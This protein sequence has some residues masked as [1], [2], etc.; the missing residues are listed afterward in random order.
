MKQVIREVLGFGDQS[1]QVPMFVYESVEEADKDAGRQGAGLEEMNNNLIYR[2]CQADARELIV[3]VVQQLTK[4][5]FLMVD[6]GEKDEKGQ[7][8][9]ERDMDRDSDAKYVKRA[10]TA[11]PAVTFESVQKLVTQRANGYT[12]KDEEGKDVKVEAIRTDIRRKTRAP[13]KP[14]VL[15]QRYKNTATGILKANNVAKFNKALAKFGLAQFAPT[16]KLEADVVALGWLCKAYQDAVAEEST[17]QFV[18]Q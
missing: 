16:G 4:V 18:A 9:M 14:K 6:S 1:F 17:G 12:Y 7:P 15:A 3:D 5:P 2:G 10:L 13:A 11:T 8:I